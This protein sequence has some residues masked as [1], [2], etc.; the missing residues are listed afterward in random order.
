M[1]NRVLFRDI[2]IMAWSLN[3]MAGRFLK[4]SPLV[5]AYPGNRIFSPKCDLDLQKMNAGAKNLMG[6]H[7]FRNSCKPNVG[8]GVTDFICSIS[9]MEIKEIQSVPE[10]CAFMIS[11][12]ACLWHQG[13]CITVLLVFIG[14]GKENHDVILQLLDIEKCPGSSMHKNLWKFQLP[15][16]A[17]PINLERWFSQCCQWSTDWCPL[18]VFLDFFTMCMWTGD[19][20]G[21]QCPSKLLFKYWFKDCWSWLR[22]HQTGI[23]R[24][25]THPVFLPPLQSSRISNGLS[26][27]RSGTT[28]VDWWRL[29]ETCIPVSWF[30]ACGYVLLQNQNVIFQ[31]LPWTWQ[32]NNGYRQ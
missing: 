9:W 13:R 6:S 3:I 22:W 23:H 21:C 11:G 27:L 18:I 28:S 31:S 32:W 8:N 20:S 19:W 25:W 1:L 2:Q 29:S 24:L 26:S 5:T 10:M 16:R 17:L 14:L 12:K 7:D 30:V 4:V 15:R